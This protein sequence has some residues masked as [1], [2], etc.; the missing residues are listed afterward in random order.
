[1]RYVVTGGAGF[2]GS[3]VARKLAAEGHDVVVLDDL[4]TGKRE[5][6]HNAEVGMRNAEPR[7]SVVR[8]SVA[9]AAL[10]KDC[11]E[12]ADGVFH[13][14]AVASVQRSLDEPGNCHEVN[15][16]GTLNVLEAARKCG[17]RRVVLSSSAAVY[18]DN[19]ALPLTENERPAPISPYGLHKQIGEEY[20]KLYTRRGWVEVAALRYFNVFGPRQDPAGDYAAVIPKFISALVAGKQ[21]T[22]FGDGLQTRDFLYVEDVVKAN[23]LAM[24]VREAAGETFNICAGCE[25]SLLDLLAELGGIMEKK[26]GPVFLPAREGDIRRSMG[27]CSKAVCALKPGAWTAFPHGLRKTVDWFA[28]VQA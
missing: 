7:L 24:Q 15:V 8:G 19:P 16:T 5:N 10:V 27:D 25:T 13:L 18:G 1:M 4:S 20:G 28:H 6:L 9:D 17:V 11:V 3:A 21:P 12:G 22:V 26:P 14:A 2:I 23:I